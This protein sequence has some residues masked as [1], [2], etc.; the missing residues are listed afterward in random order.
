MPHLP[1]GFS[2]DSNIP[3]NRFLPPGYWPNIKGWLEDAKRQDQKKQKKQKYI[4]DGK[5]TRPVKHLNSLLDYQ[6]IGQLVKVCNASKVPTI[7]PSGFEA[8]LSEGILRRKNGLARLMTKL[9]KV[10]TTWQVQDH[11]VDSVQQSSSV[12]NTNGTA[13]TRTTVTTTA[14][15]SVSACDEQQTRAATAQQIADDIAKAQAL[16]D[17]DELSRLRQPR[18]VERILLKIPSFLSH[19]PAAYQRNLVRGRFHFKSFPGTEF[20]ERLDRWLEQTQLQTPTVDEGVDVASSD[21]EDTQERSTGE[22]DPLLDVDIDIGVQV[23]MGKNKRV[24]SYTHEKKFNKTE[25]VMATMTHT[26]SVLEHE[27]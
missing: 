12:S 15:M 23:T 17:V 5:K 13:T 8:D 4:N 9:G 10:A 18:L 2:V 16:Y 3:W 11:I 27:P 25:R 6:H 1:P 14:T 24:S 20:E 21:G 19:A 22:L 26:V 7:R